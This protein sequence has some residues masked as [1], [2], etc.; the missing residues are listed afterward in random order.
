MLHLTD[1]T[2]HLE[3][4][5]SSWRYFRGYHYY[6]WERNWILNYTR[7]TQERFTLLWLHPSWQLRINGPTEK[8]SI[9]GRYYHHGSLPWI[10]WKELQWHGPPCH[11]QKNWYQRRCYHRCLWVGWVPE[12][13]GA[14]NDPPIRL[15]CQTSSLL[16]LKLNVWRPKRFLT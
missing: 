11:Y 13:K 7:V 10:T 16:F 15:W 8:P 12:I 2:K 14:I 6:L 1:P 5:Y 3:A 4:R 9:N